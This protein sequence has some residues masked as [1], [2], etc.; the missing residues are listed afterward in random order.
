VTRNYRQSSVNSGAI[1]AM[2]RELASGRNAQI[3]ASAAERSGSKSRIEMENEVWQEG[4][5]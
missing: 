4:H 5:K 3:A 1:P 2:E